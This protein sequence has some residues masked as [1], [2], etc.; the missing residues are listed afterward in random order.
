MDISAFAYLIII[1]DDLNNAIGNFFGIK[2]WLEAQY[3][4]ENQVNRESQFLNAQNT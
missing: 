3:S 4:E 2:K 1:H